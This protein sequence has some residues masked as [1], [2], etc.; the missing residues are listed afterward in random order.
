MQKR[1]CRKL[2]YQKDGICK[3]PVCDCGAT[4]TICSTPNAALPMSCTA[5]T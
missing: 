4:R 2:F 3:I 1:L 5:A